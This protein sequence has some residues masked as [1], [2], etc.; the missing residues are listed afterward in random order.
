MKLQQ[1]RNRIDV[2]DNEILRLVA[3]RLTLAIQ[4]R[5]HKTVSEDREREQDVIRAARA[6]ATDPLDPD[7][8]EKLVRMLIEHSIAQQRSERMLVGFQGEPGAYGHLAARDLVP[9]GAF[10]PCE[11]FEDVFGRVQRSEL[12][13]AVVPVENSQMGAIPRVNELLATTDLHV[14]GETVISVH[15]CLLAPPGTDHRELRVVYSHPQALAQCAGFLRRNHLEPRSYFDTSGAA[16]MVARERPHAAAAIAS[17]L[18]GAINGLEVLLRDIEDSPTN[19]TRFLLLSCTPASG[20]DKCSLAFTTEH[21]A[22]GLY[23]VLAE[24]ARRGINL[25]RIASLPIRTEPGRTSF[26]LDLEGSEQDPEVREALDRVEELTD[27]L[28]LMGCYPSAGPFPA[29]PETES[30]P[31]SAQ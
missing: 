11:E 16:R 27:E 6:T 18:S 26:F 17:E 25:T 1:I 21:R 29:L 19:A 3:E 22:G 7:L 5:R 2:I 8:A 13:V 31:I 28:R 10:I 14:A 24:F 23:E 9:S 12:D 4:T 15:H 30:R 20:G